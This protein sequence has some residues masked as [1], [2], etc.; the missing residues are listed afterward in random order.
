MDSLLPLKK[1]A[2]RR[3]SPKERCSFGLLLF[4]YGERSEIGLL[5]VGDTIA[6]Y[7]LADG[8]VVR[9]WGEAALLDVR[10]RRFVLLGEGCGKVPG[11]H[12]VYIIFL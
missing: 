8:F 12:H 10:N 1:R 7:R 11:D 6:F 9:P 5:L 3:K 4:S 2:D